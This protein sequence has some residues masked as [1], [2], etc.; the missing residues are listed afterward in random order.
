MSKILIK[1]NNNTTPRNFIFAVAD[2][3]N[4][5]VRKFI[6]NAK[7]ALSAKAKLSD[8]LEDKQFLY[9]KRVTDENGSE[10]IGKQLIKFGDEE[11]S[12]EEVIKNVEEQKVADDDTL[13]D[14][15]ESPKNIHD[16]NRPAVAATTNVVE[17]DDEFI[18][19]LQMLRDG[20]T[21]EIGA[22]Q[23]YETIVGKLSEYY[24]IT[25]EKR[26]KDAENAVRDIMDEEKK[27]IGEFQQILAN[28][29]I[30]EETLNEEGK[31]EVDK[32]SESVSDSET[33]IN[34]INLMRK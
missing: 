27:H 13:F 15:P 3:R 18:N 1:D 8:K 34:D 33:K 23:L 14:D 21:S 11:T 31:E 26:Y 10:Y 24:D 32:E 28:L 20:I 29:D 2:K 25:A 30:K 17:Q 12:T 19:T 16:D 5:K 4:T 22:I 6:V 7:D 9:I